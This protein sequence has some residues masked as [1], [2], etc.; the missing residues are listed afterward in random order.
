VLAFPELTTIPSTSAKRSASSRT[1]GSIPVPS[2]NSLQAILPRTNEDLKD[3]A[4]RVLVVFFPFAAGFYLSYL[5][6]TINSL[7]SGQLISQL[8]LDAADLGLLTSVYFLT[9]AAAQLPVGLLLD[10]YGPRRIQSALLLI[11][12]GG[13]AIFGVSKE[14]T[15]LVFGRGLVGFGMAASM[16][17]ALKAI[18]LWFPTERV[19]LVSGY[20]VMLGT[21]GA[22]TATVPLEALMAWMGWQALFELLAGLT[23]VCAI[24]T[25]LIVPDGPTAERV[26]ERTACVNLRA[27][28]ADVRFWRLAPLSAT[29]IGTSWSL[30]SLWAASWL[31]D[32]ERL[33]PGA[34][35]EHLF[36]MAVAVSASALL[37]GHTAN[38][39]RRR[40]V[41]PRQLLASVATLFIVCQF[42]LVQRWP[43][44]TYFLWALVAAV[45]AATVLSYSI[46]AEYVPRDLTGR[47]NAALNV[48]QIGG[49]FVLQISTGMIVQQWK[50]ENG[51]YPAAAYQTAFTVN[52]ALQIVA[53]LWFE[54]PRLQQFVSRFASATNGKPVSVSPPP[55]M[56][57][58]AAASVWIGRVDSARAERLNWRL[59]ALGS[60]VLLVLFAVGLVIS[61]SRSGRVA[62]HT[63]E[64][65]QLGEIRSVQLA[66]DKISPPEAEIAY[67]LARF[68]KNIRSLSID[69]IVVRENW[70]DAYN[71]VTVP[72]ALA[73]NEYARKSRHFA[74][75]G[76]QAVRVNVI[77]VIR[78]SQDSFEIVWDEAAYPSGM[79]TNIQR[80]RGIAE[81]VFNQ[82]T[83]APTLR[84][85]LGVYVNAFHWA[86]EN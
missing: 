69:P 34:L 38:C 56:P 28:Y 11:A 30:Q 13:A 3:N 15:S 27:V 25:Y 75:V 59:A 70:I 76:S 66:M 8:S 82:P 16:T 24:V 4:R 79:A 55:L 40:G 20:M 31:R 1:D 23:A 68:V 67:F 5:F 18:V 57:H 73:F 41:A 10:R 50:T 33:E 58:A 12:A 48:F 47:A 85:P 74:R 77:Y 49:A 71:Y 22:V 80:F 6:R 36:V 45:G 37:L 14:F 72:A 84:N 17:A 86:Q 32:V 26:A 54:M 52:L 2:P 9:F 53:L 35:V 7:L 46:Q 44:P 65:I 62:V 39:L 51:H 19:A 29:C 83:A 60:T 64:V 61:T 21:L 63:I 42:A 43:L 81:V 78:A